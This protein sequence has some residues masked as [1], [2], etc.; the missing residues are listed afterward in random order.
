MKQPRGAEF[1]DELALE[2]EAAVCGVRRH[3]LEVLGPDAD[4]HV[5]ADGSVETSWLER[6]LAARCL[7]DARGD[8]FARHQVHGRRA[9]EGR[10][11]RRCGPAIHLRRLVHLLNAAAV[12]NHHLIGERHRL[13][14][15]VRNEDA[16]RL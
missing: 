3:V 16:G 7:G 15:V 9:D 14:L 4:L 6:E 1:L 5:A 12:H 2:G 10:N 13:H 8:D 11:E